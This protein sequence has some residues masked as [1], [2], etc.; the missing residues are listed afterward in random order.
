MRNNLGRGEVVWDASQTFGG[1]YFYYI[2]TTLED[3]TELRNY[4]R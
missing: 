2:S 1:I 3:K 4:L